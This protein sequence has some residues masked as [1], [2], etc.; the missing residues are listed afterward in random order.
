MPLWPAS[1]PDIAELPPLPPRFSWRLPA[2]KR[3]QHSMPEGR[4]VVVDGGGMAVATMQPMIDG[5]RILIAT[6]RPLV[7]D[8][9]ARDFKGHECASHGFVVCGDMG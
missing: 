7:A 2:P 6:H 3:R 5:A 9:T 8:Q 1:T 4:Q